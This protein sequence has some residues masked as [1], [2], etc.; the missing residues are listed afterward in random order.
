MIV[1]GKVIVECKAAGALP[2]YAQR[3][4]LSYLNATMMEVGVILHFGPEAKYYRYV[5]TL[6]NRRRGPYKRS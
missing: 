6:N 1:D 3:Q 4:I 5:D 2:P